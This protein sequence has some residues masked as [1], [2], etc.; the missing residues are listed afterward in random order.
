MAV[1]VRVPRLI[2]L[3]RHHATSQSVRPGVGILTRLARSLSELGAKLSAV[4]AH[5]IL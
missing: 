5:T 2:A 3:L 1:P 4:V